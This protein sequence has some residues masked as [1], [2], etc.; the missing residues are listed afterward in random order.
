MDF[1]QIAGLAKLFF[2]AFTV[3]IPL[4]FLRA[5]SRKYSLRWFVY[6][7]LSIPFIVTLRIAEGFDWRAIPFTLACAVAGQMVGGR[8]KERQRP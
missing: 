1:H 7:H 5:G 3:N 8:W 4:G 6:I 2:F